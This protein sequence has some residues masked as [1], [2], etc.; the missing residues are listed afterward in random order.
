VE[1]RGG[2]LQ[3]LKGRIA[4]W[5][6]AATFSASSFLSLTA[7]SRFV[8]PG[9]IAGMSAILVLSLIAAVVPGSV[10]IDRAA[11]A[12][13]TVDAGHQTF[14]RR[15]GPRR[16]VA[17]G[18]AATT[19]SVTAAVL[20]HLDIV[21][22]LAIGVQFLPALWLSALRGLLMG[23]ERFGSLGISYAIEGLVRLAAS[24]VLGILW[25]EAGFGVGLLVATL[26]SAIATSRFRPSPEQVKAIGL[27]GGTL[28]VGRPS[29]ASSAVA[30]GSAVSLANADLLFVSRNLSPSE[31]DA[32]AVAAIP[33]KGVFIALF[34]AGWMFFAA[35]RRHQSPVRAVRLGIGTTV[36]GL[37]LAVAATALAPLVATVLGRPRPPSAIVAMLSVSMAAASGTW[38][39]TNLA[40]SLGA[41]RAWMPPLVAICT[42]ILLGRSASSSVELAISLLVANL[43]GFFASCRYTATLHAERRPTSVGW[44]GLRSGVGNFF[45]RLGMAPAPGFVCIVGIAVLSVLQQPGKL[46]ADTKIDFAIDPVFFLRRAYDMWEPLGYFGHVQ[47]QS[48][49]YFF[50][51]GPYFVAAKYL[52]FPMWVAQRLWIFGIAASAF[53]GV[54]FLAGRLGI[55]TPRTRI[56]AAGFYVTAPVFASIVAFTS[57]AALPGAVLPWMLAPLIPGGKK[58]TPSGAAAR[59]AVAFAFSGAVNAVASLAVLPAVAT[60]FVTERIVA[61]PAD[62]VG[63]R[64]A[65]PVTPRLAGLTVLFYGAVISWWIVPLMLLRVYGFNFLKYTE[66]ADAAASTQSLF[67]S[68]RGSGYWLAYLNLRRP[69]LPGGWEYVSSP[70]LVAASGVLVAISLA[71]LA[72]LAAKRRLFAPLLF[73]LGVAATSGAYWFRGSGLAHSQIL[74]LLNGPLGA[75]RNVSKFVFLVTLP[76][77]LGLAHL[78]PTLS[79]LVAGR[80]PSARRSMARVGLAV[81]SVCLLVMAIPAAKGNLATP[82]GFESIPDYWREAVDWLEANSAGGRVVVIPG[83]PF[84]EYDW[85]R[86]LDDILQSTSKIPW[87]LRSLV[88]LGGTGSTRL[89]DALEDHLLYQVPSPSLAPALASAGIEYLV[90]RNDLEWRLSGAPRPL[91]VKRTIDA[92]GGFSEVAS[93]GSSTEPTAGSSETGRS[94]APDVV[95]DLGMSDEESKMPRV[96]IYRVG[97]DPNSK[98]SQT[99][100]VPL[101][102]VVV[103]GGGSESRLSLDSYESLRE[104]PFILGSDSESLSA[105]GDAGVEPQHYI[106]TDDLRLR[107]YD[108]GLVH[109]NYSYTLAAGERPPGMGSTGKGDAVEAGISRGG[110][111]PREIMPE[112]DDIHKTTRSFDGAAQIR[113]SSYSSWLVQLPELRPYAAFDGDRSTA[114]VSGAPGRAT[115]EW[116]QIEFDDAIDLPEVRIVPLLDNPLRPLIEQVE[117]VTEAGS[118]VSP[119]EPA[120]VPQAVAVPP[121]ATKWLRIVLA[122][123]KGENNSGLSG[124]GIREVLIPGLSVREVVEAPSDYAAPYESVIFS[125]RRLHASLV[126]RSDEEQVLRRSFMLRSPGTYSI[127]GRVV[128]VAGDELNRLVEI[129]GPLTIAAS[130][131]FNGLPEFRSSNLLDGDTTTIWAAA[132][133][134]PLPNPLGLW[135]G[136][137]AYS[138][139]GT[140]PPVFEGIQDRL[141]TSPSLVLNFGRPVELNE[142]EIITTTAGTAAAPAKIRLVGKNDVRE[143]EVAPDGWVRFEPFITD[144]LRL[145]FVSVKRRISIDGMTGIQTPLPVGF[146]ELHIPALSDVAYSVPLPQEEFFLPCGSGPSVLVDGEP[147]DTEVS[148]RISDLVFMRPLEFRACRQLEVSTHDTKHR[149]EGIYGERPLAISEVMINRSDMEGGSYPRQLGDITEV[150]EWGPRKRILHIEPGP[151]RALYVNENFNAGWR[152]TSGDT[153]LKPIKLD[154]WKQGFVVPAGLEGEVRLEYVPG[155]L[156]SLSIVFGLIVVGLVMAFAYLAALATA[157]PTSTTGSGSPSRSALTYTLESPSGRRGTSVSIALMVCA[158]S[159]LVSTAVFPV[160]VLVFAVALLKSAKAAQNT[161]RHKATAVFCACV[162]ASAF[163][164]A[165]ISAALGLPAAPADAKGP[166]GLTAQIAAAIVMVFALLPAAY[167]S[168]DN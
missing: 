12:V 92:S 111:T 69:W 90:V 23:S 162:A 72:F 99:G 167:D 118:V 80:H 97:S 137:K 130:S 10:Q 39:L 138:R 154:G 83:A 156:H 109:Y 54:S 62:D 113:S 58:W 98:T 160:A 134:S 53:C 50:P 15:I 168:K 148:G 1:L 158:V 26:V 64:E 5:L 57:A 42:W 76:L 44:N 60:F 77:A 82:G 24:T 31:A 36:A 28:D 164:V 79:Q 8:P 116:L 75:F 32:F 87:A 59:S 151:A 123:V 70:L 100:V 16:A 2:S 4:F 9:T 115:G 104:T 143:A 13:D 165:T 46:V 27:S 30:I 37:V 94:D 71:G 155:R 131:T 61:R 40:L 35:V 108:F 48:Y 128:P 65:V 105:L 74:D 43:L 147:F 140:P 153:E 101:S 142:V 93:F 78:G 84:A 20:L 157:G 3:D 136:S 34:V 146:S 85:G 29:I 49:G 21:G 33:A 66:S 68:M 132:L 121:G 17:L 152:A 122:S 166:F 89:L 22:T 139:Q 163:L 114:W 133:P 144:T 95:E 52:G 55:G 161:R 96:V 47:N 18:L 41:K 129:R 135:E 86:P 125:R 107:D 91:Q 19:V 112:T 145:E 51:M 119:L 117:I 7:L 6:G 120:E 110:P 124:A 141:D 63:N 159:L 127:H 88:P 56:A 14:R 102:D 81:V 103:V 150:L 38:A 73:L 67:E 45:R 106:A 126:G 25:V 149:I 11:Y